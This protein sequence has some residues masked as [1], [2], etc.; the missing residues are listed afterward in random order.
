MKVL[1]NKVR[2]KLCLD[3]IESTDQ[4]NLA[5]CTCKNIAISGGSK[6][7]RRHGATNASLDQY[8]ELSQ[9]EYENPRD[10]DFM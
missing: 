3:E 6:A 2:C 10:L 1:L 5:W 7:I 8:D 9:W 4:H